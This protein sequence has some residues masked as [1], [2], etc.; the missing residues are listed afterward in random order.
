VRDDLVAGLGAGAEDEVED[1]GGQPRLVENL[2]DADGRGGRQGRRLEDD[3]VAGDERGRELPDGDGDGE[4]PGGDDGDDAVRL[5]DGVGEVAREF[6]GDGLAVHA[7]RLAGAELGDVDGAL[8]LAARLRERLAL[9]ARE[10]RGQLLFALLHEP[11]GARHDAAARRGG[12]GSPAAEGFR[13]GLDGAARLLARREAD[14][15]D[16]VVRVRGVEVVEVVRGSGLDPLPADE[17]TV[18]F[19]EQNSQETVF[20][21]Q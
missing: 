17:V 9:L 20:R 8:Q 14:D 6:G 16:A 18:D 10:Q 11:R 3:R 13:S 7:A 21:R 2:D 15:A 12:R 5:P 4:V 19:H 1:A